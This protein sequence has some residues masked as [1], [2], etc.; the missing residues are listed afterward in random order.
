M[1]K[2][3]DIYAASNDGL[4]IILYYYPQAEGCVTEP[5]K[6]FKRRLDEDDASACLKKYGDCY[7]VTDF[8]DQGTAMSPIDVCMYEENVNFQEAVALLAGRYNVTDELKRTVNKPEIRKRP[9]TAEEK[10]GDRFFELEKGFTQEQLRVMGP[11]VEK[12]HVEALH[13]HVVKSISYVKN[14]EVTTKLSTPT[15]PIFIRECIIEDSSDPKGTKKFFKIYEPLNP[16]KQWRFS[17]TPEG[18]KPK[19][20]INGLY[21]LRM[22]YA[23]YNADEEAKFKNL[24]ENQNKPYRMQKLKEAF[25]CS[26]ERDSLCVRALGYHPLWFNSETYK[27]SEE[28]MHEVKK[29]V[30]TI[31]N[32]PDI[33]STGVAKGRELALRFLDIH[34]VWLPKELSKYKD[35]RGKPRKDFRDFVELHPKGKDF[36]NLLALAMPAQF[37][38]ESYNERSKKRGFDIDTECLHYFLTLNGFYTLFDENSDDVRFIRIQGNIVEEVDTT[39]ISNFLCIFVRERFLQREIRNLVKNSQRLGVASLEKLDRVKLDFTN[40]TKQSQYMF[41]PKDTWRIT[42][43]GITS[44][45]S[46][47]GDGSRYVWNTNVLQH[48]VSV[49]PP[50]FECKITEDAEGTLHY[51]IDVKNHESNM[52]RYIINTSRVHWRKELEYDFEDESV[53]VAEAY[54]KAHK[55]D[56]AGPNLTA[57]EIQEQKQ[58]LI[59]KLFAIGYNMHRYKS[60][61]QAWAIYAM[62]NRIGDDGQ[63]NGRSGKSFLFKTFGRFMRTVELSGRNPKLM[64][65]PHVYDRVN[66]HTD[67]ILV[68]DCDKYL[69]TSLFYDSI[70]G[71]MTVNPKNNR[72]F[73]IEFENSPKFGF[74]TNYVPSEFDPSTSARLLYMVFSDYYHERTPENDYLETRSIRDDF[75]K[76]LFTD[77][78][79]EEW[80]QD[81][82]FFAQCLAFY[83]KMSG[84]GIKIQPPLENIMK[85]KYKSDMGANFEDWAYQYF[86]EEGE[87]LDTLL[88]RSVVMEDFRRF[89]NLPKCTMQRFTKAL[90]G[91]AALCPYVDMINPPEMLNTSGRLMRKVDGETQEMIFVRTV[92]MREYMQKSRVDGENGHASQGELAFVPLVQQDD[93]KF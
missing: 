90:K 88:V 49:L 33:D 37:W 15:Y 23:K 66:Q 59:S 28:E 8:G 25:I 73:F 75:N 9:A 78:T 76:N 63:C 35:Q 74:T 80:N 10:E 40:C 1:I 79:E 32:I 6:K 70:T 34:T 11:R 14:R 22:A 47:T 67:F 21:E 7:K 81:I 84:Q 20:Y 38:V 48:K 42:G 52:F 72:S 44:F 13:W 39:D 29:Y 53:E 62:D 19:Q 82:N 5:K 17:Y 45:P 93:E 4:D 24:P 91:F 16:D 51:D 86:S 55:F 65:N 26:G 18:V 64:D 27:V 69:Q 36:R 85:R 2:A 50:M 41:F 57:A 68:D 89:A 3:Q 71:G 61:S 58:N 92:K 43:D 56:I 87:H 46:K 54:R 30:E 31:Y 77:Y 60:P 83:L 12:E